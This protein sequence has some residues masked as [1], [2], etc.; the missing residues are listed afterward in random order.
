MIYDRIYVFQTPIPNP[1]A[2]QI[3]VRAFDIGLC[4]VTEDPGPGPLA[5]GSIDPYPAPARWPSDQQTLLPDPQDHRKDVQE[6][7]P[8]QVS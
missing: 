7:G 5:G 6:A 4:S 8:G 1:N 3:R 2:T